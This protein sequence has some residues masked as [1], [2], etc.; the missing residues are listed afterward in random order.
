MDPITALQK[1]ERLIA[2]LKERRRLL[3]A[4]SGGVDSTL[5]LT[6]AHDALGENVM[7]AI[8]ESPIHPDQETQYAKQFSR[9]RGIPHINVHTDEMDSEDFLRN[10]PDRCYFC[11]KIIMQHLLELA[12]SE[13]IP[14][15]AHGANMDDVNDHRPGSRAAAEAGAVAPLYDA[16][17]TKSEIRHI[18]KEMGLFT[19]D[20]PAMA[21]LA[22]RIPYGSRITA[23]KLKTIEAAE[24][25]IR[26]QG[27][28]EIRV[29]HH[30]PVARIEIGEQEINRF[31][32]Q[33]LRTMIAARL[34][35]LGFSHVTL[36]LEGYESGK[37]NR[38]LE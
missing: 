31:M 9:Q 6:I 34:R 32:E 8:C 38:E 29:R 23:Q 21:C 18:S 20:K 27:I 30:G 11:K 4:Y 25:F 22:T 28:R 10:G 26:N 12:R 33:G 5:L 7:A 3:V 1:K 17:L 35:F 14:C 36:D 2:D 24:A 15:I 37:M 16:R 19:W 13:D